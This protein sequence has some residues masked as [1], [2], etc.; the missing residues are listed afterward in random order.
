MGGP[1][2]FPIRADGQQAGGLCD[3]ENILVLMEDG[4]PPRLPLF[5]RAGIFGWMIHLSFTFWERA[6]PGAAG[7]WRSF[8]TGNSLL[9]VDFPPYGFS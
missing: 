9:P 5:G 4:Q 2:L 8:S 7:F 6:A 3:H 1:R